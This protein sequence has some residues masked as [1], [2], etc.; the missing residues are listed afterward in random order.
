MHRVLNISTE[1]AFCLHSKARVPYHIF[2]EVEHTDDYPVQSTLNNVS[3][4]E[5]EE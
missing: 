3:Y 1:Y 2:I 4:Q 5:E